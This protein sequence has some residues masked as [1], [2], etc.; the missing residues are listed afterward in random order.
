MK[1]RVLRIEDTPI[2]KIDDLLFRG[3]NQT[4]QELYILNTKLNE[5]PKAAFKVILK[6]FEKF[7]AWR[8]S[9]CSIFFSRIDFGQF[10]TAENR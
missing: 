6:W 3:V 9:F 1:I 7:I 10:N 2:E 5:F 8:I 4:L